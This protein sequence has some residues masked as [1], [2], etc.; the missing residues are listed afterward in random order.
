MPLPRALA[1]PLTLALSHAL[2]YYYDACAAYAAHAWATKK[3]GHGRAEE[4]G[5]QPRRSLGDFLEPVQGAD[6]QIQDLSREPFQA[7]HAGLGDSLGQ[8]LVQI[9]A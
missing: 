7:E 5:P 2:S 1:R 9:F 3:P 6:R 8:G 4:K